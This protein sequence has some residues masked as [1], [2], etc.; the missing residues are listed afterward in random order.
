VKGVRCKIKQQFVYK[1]LL[2]RVHEALAN[3]EESP[4][5]TKSA[6]EKIK[7]LKTLHFLQRQLLLLP[8]IYYIEMFLNYFPELVGT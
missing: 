7:Q 3:I 8:L 5:Y 4:Q 1:I 2:G 6:G